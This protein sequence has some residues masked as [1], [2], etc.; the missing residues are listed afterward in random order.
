MDKKI[1]IRCR[2]III[3]NNKLLVVKHSPKNT[4]YVLPGG[5]LEWGEKIK[6]CLSREL[7]EE[8]GIKGDVGRLFYVNNYISDDTGYVNNDTQSVEFFFEIKNSA[9]YAKMNKP[10]GSHADE[11]YEL[12]WVSKDDGVNVMPQIIDKALRD[13]TLES[14][15]VRFIN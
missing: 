5:H 3:H 4:Y 11:I 7:E 10:S 8:L 12:K 9:D 2:A 13:G 1:I 6:E 14:D 15:L